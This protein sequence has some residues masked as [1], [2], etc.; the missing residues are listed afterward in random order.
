MEKLADKE[1]KILD[2]E[3]HKKYT[4]AYEKLRLLNV[5]SNEYVDKKHYSIAAGALAIS[6]AILPFIYNSDRCDSCN[7]IVREWLYCIGI[8][9]VIFSLCINLVSHF[10]IEKKALDGMNTI[11]N[12][13]KDKEDYKRADLVIIFNNINTKSSLFNWSMLITLLLGIGLLF[14]FIILNL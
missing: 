9:L 5:A 13:I 10:R 7:P 12:K 8:G 6:V 2:P 14:Y 11:N 1:N 4:S 3:D